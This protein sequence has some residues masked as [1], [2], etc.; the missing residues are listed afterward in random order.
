MTPSQLPDTRI[1]SI[2]LRTSGP[3]AR[4]CSILDIGAAWICGGEITDHFAMVCRAFDG[5]HLDDF[6]M[7]RNRLAGRR[8]GDPDIPI[9]A[10][11]MDAFRAWSGCDDR[12]IIIAGLRPS[13][14]RSFLLAAYRRSQSGSHREGIAPRL[15][16]RVLDLGSLFIASRISAGLS[17]P[18]EGYSAGEICTWANVPRPEGEETALS[19]AL[20]E[21]AVAWQLLKIHDPSAQ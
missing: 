7:Q 9:E 17:V 8:D 6:T 18:S 3:D 11:V 1:L 21:R 16:A 19:I 4:C 20:R 12:S 13:M 15:P 14:M 10:E 5:A 2:A